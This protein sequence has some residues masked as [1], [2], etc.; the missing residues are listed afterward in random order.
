MSMCG[1]CFQVDTPQSIM[2]EGNDYYEPETDIF[3]EIFEDSTLVNATVMQ[4]AL[5]W[6][7][8]HIVIGSCDTE[9]WVEAMRDRLNMI[10]PKWDAIFDKAAD[11]DLTDL[12]ELSYE[13]IIQRT[14]MEGTDGDVSTRTHEG[15][16]VRTSEHESL[17]QTATTETKY[18]DSRQTDTVRPGVTDTDKYAP[19]T[20]DRETYAEDRNINA[21]TFGSML[22]NYPSILT[23]FVDEFKAYFV[24]RW[25]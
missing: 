14:P 25:Y 18:L 9:E 17:P 3:A 13:R 1:C 24:N 23:G 11:T 2:E 12:T 19:N 16:D 21:I 5:W 4:Q 8:R 6:R 7:Y 22:N 20:Q 15:S 10:G